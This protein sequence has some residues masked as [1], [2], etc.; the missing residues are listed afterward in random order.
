MILPILAAAAEAGGL[1]GSFTLGMAGAG[2]GIGVGLVGAKAAEA[3][4]R[5][6]GAFGRVLTVA[7]LGMALA[8]AIAIYALILAF[9]GR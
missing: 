5:N 4:G 2:A 8:E 3:V 7:I 1:T 9:G 6:P